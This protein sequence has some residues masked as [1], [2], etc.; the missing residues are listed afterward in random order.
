MIDLETVALARGRG[1]WSETDWESLP[2]QRRE[3]RQEIEALAAEREA[4]KPDLSE[5]RINPNVAARRELELLPGIGEVRALQIIEGR[6]EGPYREPE[7]LLRLP[8][9]GPATLDRIRDALVFE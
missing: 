3:Q 4:A 5:L 9:F 8:G 7:D 6:N 1:V 2:A